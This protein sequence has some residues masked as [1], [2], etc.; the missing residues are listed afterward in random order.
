MNMT[1]QILPAI[2]ILLLALMG[3]K[4][5]MQKIVK[6]PAPFI[7][8]VVVGH[9][10]IYTV[11]A[12]LRLAVRHADPAGEVSDEPYYFTAYDLDDQKPT[13]VPLYQEI[14]I[15]KDEDGNMTIVSPRE[16][17]D[18]VKS[19]R[20][21]YALELKYY[22][23][24]G[25]LIN[26]Q[27]TRWHAMEGKTPRDVGYDDPNST[28][29]V[30]Q[31]FFTIDNYSLS[32]LPIAF[33]MT[34]DS[35]Y[36]DRYTFETDG[37][38]GLLPATRMSQA[39]VFVP[40]EGH[41]PNGLRY[42]YALALESERRTS[43]KS[44]EETYRYQGR[45][46]RLYK[47][48]DSYA[49]NK[50]TPEIF[51]YEY[52]D[53]DPVEESL[54]T[55][56]EDQDDLGRIRTGHVVNL[57]RFRRGIYEEGDGGLYPLEPMGMKGI[58]NF[59]KSDILFQ[60]KVSIAHILTQPSNGESTRFLFG[61]YMTNGGNQASPFDGVTTYKSYEIS[62][63]WNSYDMC[64]PISVRVIADADGPVERLVS[65]VK[66]YYPDAS[67]T[68]LKE[69]FYGEDNSYYRRRPSVLF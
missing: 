20:Y 13:P 19:S 59:K 50:L 68:E 43:T 6:A 63:S 14:K 30:H 5:T 21:C 12:I 34:P 58:L 53:T 62:R 65:D 67:E 52:R 32:G 27:F 39:N 49:L 55:V 45:D 35:L 56:L 33:P 3:C 26:H 42:D 15:S 24:N 41:K 4:D 69:M 25:Q 57:L 10:Q 44:V 18:V 28:L 37:A 60:L 9:E 66:R 2:A 29:L 7:E 38:G 31:H 17:F 47:T 8:T 36:I 40:T 22:D 46:Y 51:D 1:R 64:Y 23:M 61:K 11:Q 54:G 48:L 16:Y